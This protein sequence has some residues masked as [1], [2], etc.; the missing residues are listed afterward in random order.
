M[1]TQ[2]STSETLKTVCNNI[3]TSVTN[4]K[5]QAIVSTHKANA[6]NKD[7][8]KLKNNIQCIEK[9]I[10]HFKNISS[11]INH[12]MNQFGNKIKLHDNIIK[13]NT[14]KITN[15]DIS[16]GD[17]TLMSNKLNNSYNELD[18]KIK[19]Q[20]TC[21][22]NVIKYVQDT[23]DTLSKKCYK[24]LKDGIQENLTVISKTYSKAESSIEDL[25]RNNLEL[26]IKYEDRLIALEKEKIELFENIKDHINII[27]NR[28][29]KYISDSINNKF[30]TVLQDLKEKNEQINE[31]K[32]KLSDLEKPN[33]N[34]KRSFDSCIKE[35]DRIGQ[36]K[37][38]GFEDIRN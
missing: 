31:I 26:N 38:F 27:L 22:D 36:A 25:K 14:D 29:D 37:E 23:T 18:K 34:I 19:V 7:V 35:I 11:D 16:I 13:Q 21:I 4:A 33:D 1:I 30:K 17:F 5:A 12:E 20:D 8:L 15:H 3:Y 32:I 9:E 6:I 10:G 24:N 2:K 28:Q